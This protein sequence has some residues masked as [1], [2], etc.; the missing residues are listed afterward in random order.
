MEVWCL[1]YAQADEFQSITGL[2]LSTKR[3]SEVYF[4]VTSTKCIFLLPFKAGNMEPV[5]PVWRMMMMDD[6]IVFICL[7]VSV[8]SCHCV[9]Q[10]KSRA[11]V[12]F[13]P[14]NF[15]QRV[16]PGERVW[17]VT[18]GFHGNR[19]KGQMT[20]KEAQVSIHALAL[21]VLNTHTHTK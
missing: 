11:K 18:A 1:Y 2:F 17:K 19:D 7:T 4:E 6:D 16:R 20:V 15:V 10:G 21:P 9:Y 5:S 3:Q 12:G 8:C 13:F 14:A